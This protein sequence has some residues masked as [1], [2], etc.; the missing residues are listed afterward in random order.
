[1]SP[2]ADVDHVTIYSAGNVVTPGVFNCRPLYVTIA[3]NRPVLPKAGSQ[4]TLSLILLTSI[5]GAIWLSGRL[6]ACVFAHPVS[7]LVTNTEY[8]KPP[9]RFATTGVVAFVG[10][11]EAPSSDH[12]I[13]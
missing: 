4:F 8:T 13:L 1:M 2:L 6:I 12:R 9:S 3:C 10:V 5:T 11:G 7:L